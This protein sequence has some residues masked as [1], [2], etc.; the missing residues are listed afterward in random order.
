MDPAP[1]A[2]NRGTGDGQVKPLSDVRQKVSAS[3]S[4]QQAV[5]GSGTQN[6]YLGE[7]AGQREPAV[8]IAAP[9]GQRD[10]SLPLRGRDE[11][12]AELAG[13]GP[14]VRVLH[15]LGGCGKTRLALEAAFRA[16]QSGLEVWWI[17]AAEAGV[18]AAG[19]RALGR[20]L[21]V[22]DADLGYGD[23]ADVIWRRLAGKQD[24]WL[25]VLD[26]ADDPQVLAGA[27]SS[28]G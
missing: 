8:S 22:S 5:L 12:L 3:G 18:L 15:G 19:M 9:V 23:A 26:S 28:R 14:W 17:S 13:P 1:A 25:L 27:G 24:P 2:G 16:Q 4:A 7:R 11:L 6:V 10:E 21:G 20:R